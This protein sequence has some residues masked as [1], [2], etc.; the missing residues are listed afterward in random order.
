MRD[1]RCLTFND[2]ADDIREVLSEMD[3]EAIAEAYNEICAKKIRYVEDSI[4]EETGE[5]DND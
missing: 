5:N 2:V 4:W 1:P 3:G